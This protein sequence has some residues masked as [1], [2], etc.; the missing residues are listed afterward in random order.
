MA[1]RGK[2]SIADTYVSIIPETSRVAGEI[3]KAFRATDREA[4]DA[5]KRWKREIESEMRDTRAHVVLDGGQARADA[6]RLKSTIERM[7]PTMHV[8][9]DHDRLGSQVSSSI[10]AHLG[11]LPRDVAGQAQNAGQQIGGSI[12]TGFGSVFS[13]GGD[14]TSIIKTV[15]IGALIPAVF[16]LG[17]VASAAAGSLGLIP[18]ALAGIAA[19]VGT[20]MIATQGFGE[21]LENLRDPEKF[22]EALQSLAPNAQQA[23]LAIQSLLPAFDHLKAAASDALFANGAQRINDLAGQYMPALEGLTTRIA[24]AINTG[25][26]G[27]FDTLMRPDVQAAVNDTF[28]SL[29]TAFEVGSQAAAPFTEAF[30]QIVQVGAQFL[31]GISAAIVDIATRFSEFV[32]QA[33]ADGSLQEWIGRGLDTLGQ[34]GGLVLSL[35]QDFGALAPI[36]EQVLP[37]IIGAIEGVSSALVAVA[38]IVSAFGPLWDAVAFAANHAATYFNFLTSFI[39][40]TLMPTMSAVS[41]VFGQAWDSISSKVSSVWSTIQPILSMMR[42]AIMGVLG[43]LG[44]ALNIASSLGVGPGMPVVAGTPVAAAGTSAADKWLAADAA[45]PKPT[46]APGLGSTRGML[47]LPGA[48]RRRDGSVGFAPLPKSPLVAPIPSSGQYA[49]PLPPPPKTSRSSRSSGSGSPAVDAYGLQPGTAINYGAQGFP[50]WVYEVAERFG[51]KASTYA[52]H[53]EKSGLNQGIDWSGPTENMQKFAEYLASV[54]GEMK[55]VIWQ[56]PTT[57]QRIG[58]ADGQLVGPGTSQPGY[59]RDDWSGHTDHVHTSQSSPIPLAGMPGYGAGAPALAGMPD[60]TGMPR[61]LREAYEKVADKNLEVQRTQDELADLDAQGTATAK[62][63][64]AV[65]DR[66]TKA[67]RERRDAVEDLATAQ[68]KANAKG[69]KSGDDMFGDL[70]K[71]LVGGFAEALGF[72]GSLFSDPTQWGITK[73]FT[74]G[75]NWATQ[76]LDG[77]GGRGGGGAG[78]G[79]GPLSGLLSNIPTGLGDLRLGGPQ[80]GPVPVMGEMPNVGGGSLLSA[81]VQTGMHGLGAMTG[82]SPG[83]GNVDHMGDKITINSYGGSGQ[84]T[85]QA[86]YDNHVLPRARAGIAGG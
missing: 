44:T 61:A 79:L 43:P 28:N 86:Y 55:Q 22:A 9:V 77:S 70:G 82:Q 72:D 46:G 49:V 1:V 17:G 84:D 6:E 83:P 10:M 7:R 20:V 26:G 78:G 62:Q 85:Y 5:G 24:T 47:D 4:R 63:R 36:G 37:G 75:V 41:V 48:Y 31:P 8:D 42:D 76:P 80:D 73:L 81:A 39:N 30:T 69:G 27:V 32:S 11:R 45:A 16:Q 3:A 51:L 33:A 25:L 35:V 13:G 65:E 2:K 71:D 18:G 21:A 64:T 40:G 57:G 29:A 53:Q 52:G 15:L 34:L 12:A 67:I 58:V 54:P 19:G 50:P 60:T 23:A 74:S 59:Y 68:E 56:N 38:P 66:L 14:F